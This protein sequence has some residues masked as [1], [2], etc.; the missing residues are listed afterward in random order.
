MFGLNPGQIMHYL[1][2]QHEQHTLDMTP[3][4]FHTK[5]HTFT[6]IVTHS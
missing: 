6:N 4:I 2:T 1:E 5:H 3:T